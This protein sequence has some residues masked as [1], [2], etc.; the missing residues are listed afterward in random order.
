MTNQLTNKQLEELL[1]IQKESDESV[2]E[3]NL[4]DSRIAYTVAFFKWFDTLETFKNWKKNQGKTLDTQLDELTDMLAFALSI[5]NQRQINKQNIK[6]LINVHNE[7][8]YINAFDFHDKDYA[9]A[10]I[11]GIYDLANDHERITP[12]KLVLAIGK[13]L[14][15]IDQLI[16]AYKKKME[17]NHVRQDGKADI[18]KGYV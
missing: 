11:R 5:A 17:R 4:E 13:R 7:T 16:E 9:D 1:K 10:F 18:E 12:L 6:K 15:S 2:S 3:L 8:D 14:Y